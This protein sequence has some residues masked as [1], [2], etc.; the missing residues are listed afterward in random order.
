MCEA[1][2]PYVRSINT[3]RADHPHNDR[4]AMKRCIFEYKT[5]NN[6]RPFVRIEIEYYPYKRTLIFRHFNLIAVLKAYAIRQI[7]PTYFTAMHSISTSAPFGK[8]F[9]ANAERAG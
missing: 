5:K 4:K 1:L 7:K 3:T 6:K 2:A 8:A 9:T